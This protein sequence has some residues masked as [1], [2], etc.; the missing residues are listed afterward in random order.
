MLQTQGVVVA[1]QAPWAWVEIERSG[2]CASCSAKAGCGTQLLGGA[3][4]APTQ[5][6]V[7]VRDLLGV[8]VGDQVLLGVSER[9]GLKAALLLYGL[10]LGGLLLGMAL[11]QPWG[12]GW[13]ALVG[14]ACMLA[15]WGLVARLS[16]PSQLAQDVTQ[17]YP[18][19][20]ARLGGAEAR[21][22]SVI[23]LVTVKPPPAADD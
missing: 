2:G 22:A 21:P 19:I 4:R 12:D 23:P 15:A 10:P 1:V 8:A 9:G 17:H 14:G 6:R 11:A 7:Q 20:L 13:A 5:Q 18:Q 16:L 3:L